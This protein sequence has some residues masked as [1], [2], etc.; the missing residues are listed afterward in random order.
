MVGYNQD[1]FT[2]YKNL[3]NVINLLDRSKL[4]SL[5]LFS[6][7]N[8]LHYIPTKKKSIYMISNQIK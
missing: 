5:C 7:T 6:Q 3:A 4:A 2:S 8:L 1:S